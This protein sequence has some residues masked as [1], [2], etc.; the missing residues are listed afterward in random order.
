MLKENIKA[1]HS[2]AEAL[3]EIETI[4]HEQVENLIK[5]GSLEAPK[6]EGGGESAEGANRRKGRSL[7]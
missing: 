7:M 4:N 1:L 2:M 3:L 6:P 5:Y